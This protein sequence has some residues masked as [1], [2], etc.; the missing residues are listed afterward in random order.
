MS[1]P[2]GWGNKDEFAFYTDCHVWVPFY[3]ISDSILL[4]CAVANC[5]MAS[6]KVKNGRGPVSV[7][8]ALCSLF[9]IFNC[10][11]RLATGWTTI[12]K[13]LALNAVLGLSLAFFWSGLIV[14]VSKYLEL[15]VMTKKL[16]QNVEP[17]LAKARCLWRIVLVFAFVSNVTTLVGPTISTRLNFVPLNWFFNSIR[18]NLITLIFL[19]FGFQVRATLNSMEMSKTFYQALRQRLDLMM[20]SF[21]IFD[22]VVT[23]LILCLAEVKF[24]FT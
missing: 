10:I 19:Y 20:M 17:I 23:G 14:Y 5:V 22:V 15:V 2:I 24:F 3:K 1:C 4:V 11:I 8:M 6:V 21:V 18:L 16:K 7:W 13:K 12:D 9:Y